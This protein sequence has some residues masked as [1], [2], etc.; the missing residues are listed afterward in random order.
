MQQESTYFLH[1][2]IA[3]LQYYEVLEVWK[4]LKIGDAVIDGSR[5]G[6]GKGY[7]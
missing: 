5:A 6:E 3:G 7:L 1:C 2:Y 4:D